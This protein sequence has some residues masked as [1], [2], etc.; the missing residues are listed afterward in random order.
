MSKHEVVEPAESDTITP[1]DAAE[2]I[3][4]HYTTLMG[5][6]ESGRLTAVRPL[7][8]GRGK[9]VLVSRSDAKKLKRELRTVTGPGRR[10]ASASK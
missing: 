3:G 8:K 9:P 6:I 4:C 1:R 5:Y 2:I 7:G 10:V